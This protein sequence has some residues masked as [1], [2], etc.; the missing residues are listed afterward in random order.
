MRVSPC[1]LR[2]A[3]H[4]VPVS[5]VMQNRPFHRVGRFDAGQDQAPERVERGA[6][7]LE[8]PDGH[9]E[10]LGTGVRAHLTIRN[11]GVISSPFSH[12]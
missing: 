3:L 7:T 8:P 11:S 10:A 5:D 12:P 2:Q 4:R 6:G 9:A 1:L